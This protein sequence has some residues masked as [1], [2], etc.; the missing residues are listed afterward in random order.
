MRPRI[1]ASIVVA[2]LIL[3][4]LVLRGA[5]EPETARARLESGLGA[6]IGTPVRL[7][8]S[9]DVR[10]LPLPRIVWTDAA[11][12]DVATGAAVLEAEAI[13]AT[14]ALAPLLHG[15]AEPV[16]FTLRGA[17]ASLR[18]EAWRLTPDRLAALPPIDVRLENGRIDLALDD[19]RSERLTAIDGR[20]VRSDGALSVDLEARWKTEPVSVD[21]G[22][23]LASPETRWRLVVGA[24]GAT[25]KASGRLRDGRPG[26]DGTLSLSLPEPNRLARL[27]ADGLARDLLRVP[28][29]ISSDLA[30]TPEAVTLTD[31]S[32]SLGRAAA[33]GS[34]ALALASPGPALSG[35]LAFDKLDLSAEPTFGDGW[36]A[37]PLDRRLLGLSLDLRMSA[38][39]LI[40]PHLELLRAA[41]SLNLAEGRLNAELG[42][43]TLWGRRVSALL[44][45]DLRDG[46]LAARLRAVAKDLPAAE[47]GRLFDVEGVEGGTVGAT[48]EGQVGCAT[49]SACT[50]AA[51]GRLRLSAA[52]LVVTGSSPFGDVTRFHPIV[53]A[54]KPSSRKSAWPEAEADLHLTGTTARVDAVEMRG[55]DAR[56]VLKGSGDLS[57]GGLDLVGHAYFRNLRATPADQPN[58]EIRIPLRVHGTIRKLAIDP[59]MPEQVPIEPSV[60]PLTPV[61]IVPPIA[62][63]P[64]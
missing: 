56:F 9:A 27:L 6:A 59:A 1:L 18:P 2:L 11:V 48:F 8:G 29:T 22:L 50:G 62:I 5:I 41:A 10:L 37:L 7:T 16:G 28:L 13:E 20:I 34:L 38:K 40:T 53:V 46:G 17:R 12:T 23:P 51:D 35:T 58:Q 24:A 43:A 63:P 25:L 54:P 47:I 52:D 60:A 44:V 31:L 36:G 49:L 32:L 30:A 15:S 57:N 39:R 21:A 64:R 45:G 19:G 3:G 14:I 42:D 26:L 33:T 4:A 61:P 55:N